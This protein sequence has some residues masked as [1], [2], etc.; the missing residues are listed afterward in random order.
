MSIAYME[1]VATELA[2]SFTMAR[3]KIEFPPILLKI[4]WAAGKRML[5]VS[6]GCSRY[7]NIYFYARSSVLVGRV[8]AENGSTKKL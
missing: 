6:A 8:G 3:Q 7:R 2:V 5:I 1:V 4:L